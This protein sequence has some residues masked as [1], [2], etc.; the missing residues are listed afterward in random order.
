MREEILR[1]LTQNTGDLPKRRRHMY[2]ILH[3][4]FFNIQLMV[5]MYIV[6]FL[7]RQHSYLGILGLV[8]AFGLLVLSVILEGKRNSEQNSVQEQRQSPNE[9]GEEVPGKDK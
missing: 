6:L 1:I 9:C 2:S 8:Y 3:L 7:S 5:I 4:L